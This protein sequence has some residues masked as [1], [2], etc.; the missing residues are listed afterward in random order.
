[1]HDQEARRLLALIDAQRQVVSRA[2]AL[3]GGMSSHAVAHRLRP[4]GPWRY[5][6]PGVYLTATGTP[7]QDQRE[8]AALLYSGPQSVITG[9]AALRHHRLPAPQSDRVDVL[10]PVRA[11]RQS[12]AYV[13]LHRTVRLPEMADVLPHRRYALP[14]RATADAT[15]WMTS[16][17]DARAV[18]AG[19]VQRG[20]C[21]VGQLTEELNAGPVR[22]S[23]LLRT[24]LSEVGA[25]VRS[26]P[27][28][29][30][31]EL[32]KQAGLPMPM[33]NPR[34]YL[35]DGTFLGCPD[36]WWPEAGVALEVDSKRW[37]LSP[38]DWERTMDRHARFGAHGIVTLHFPPS[39]LRADPA[40]VT[41]AMKSAYQ[42]GTARPRLAITALA[43]AA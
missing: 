28:A 5:L 36:A 35:A 33:F 23:A 20:A 38:A 31:R 40:R 26:A 18:V 34:L 43:A 19:V 4:G 42:A 11:Q 15:R 32:I 24:V 6:L 2:Q 9:S 8:I 14:H 29:D 22:G 39:K 10:V 13:R 41:A 17:R 7:T 3:R 30:L 1:M 16:L 37:H 21:T 25:G 27:E 12:I